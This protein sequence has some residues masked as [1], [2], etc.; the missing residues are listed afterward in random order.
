MI[1][2][3]ELSEEE[4]IKQASLLRDY[5]YRFAY[6]HARNEHDSEDITQDSL[7]KVVKIANQYDPVR[8]NLKTWVMF[9]AF[10]CIEDFFRRKKRRV[11]ASEN[12]FGN[13]DLFDSRVA[14]IIEAEEIRASLENLTG[15]E[16]REL[17][18]TEI[19][20]LPERDRF[21]LEVAYY[22]RLGY[23]DVAEYLECH[24]GTVKSRIHRARKKL[25]KNL[26]EVF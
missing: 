18:R 3:N 11:G 26:E 4:V 19:K 15:E 25:R 13:V 21:Y 7:L 5:I 16:D 17:V 9:I 20:R 2:I 1:R 24:I 22:T 14:E 10:S 23:K 6:K 12:V 8:G